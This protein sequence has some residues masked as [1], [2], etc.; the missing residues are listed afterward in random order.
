MERKPKVLLV[1]DDREIVRGLTI[2]FRAAGYDVVSAHDGAAGCAAA[3]KERPDAIMLDLRMPVM[4]GMAVL[5][6][7]RE[8]EETRWIPVVVLSANVLDSAKQR[9]LDLGARYFL[10]KPYEFDQLITLIVSAMT[11]PT[12]NPHE[13][14]GGDRK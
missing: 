7:L 4:D 10:E 8:R 3:L 1:D 14:T 5:A 6:A 12:G 13:S 11:R 9:A 2:R